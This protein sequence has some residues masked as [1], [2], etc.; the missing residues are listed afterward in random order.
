MR[1][2]LVAV[3][4]AQTAL[5]SIFVLC[6]WLLQTTN[7]VMTVALGI[8]FAAFSITA[9]LTHP[10]RSQDIYHSLTVCRTA[11]D[12]H[13]SPYL[14]TPADAPHDQW[15]RPVAAWR[16]RPFLYGPIW[17]LVVSTAAYASSNLGEALIIV[18][19]LC[20]IALAACGYF[21][22]RIIKDL[23]YAPPRAQ[24]LLSIFLFNPFLIQTSI[25]DAHNDV[26]V[27]LSILLSACYLLRKHFVLS[28]LFLVVGGYI[29]YVP[30]FL[31]PIPIYCLW[32][33]NGS[34]ARWKIVG[35]VAAF[36][37]LGA[38][39]FAPFVRMAQLSAVWRALALIDTQNAPDEYLPGTAFLILLLHVPAEIAKL[40]GV[41]I[42]AF[43]MFYA[44]AKG[45]ILLAYVLPLFA[46]CFFGA[47]FFQPWYFVWLLPFAALF[48]DP[49]EFALLTWFLVTTPEYY[50]P[51]YRALAVITAYTVAIATV[52]LYRR[53]NTPSTAQVVADRES[54][55]DGR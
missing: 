13:S 25:V 34:K 14:T 12:R 43:A 40:I 52:G 31:L 23:G 47:T 7:R 9:V 24:Y 8:V 11:L 19:V 16:D 50:A 26:L 15:S 2:P 6:M 54:G 1:R 28:A 51:Y 39:L 30:W 5:Y 44:L 37:A 32:R 46:I 20:V 35:V 3:M 18:K 29:K 55:G 45:R 49:F 33:V 42:G 22:W 10:T 48:L 4:Y 38:L 21:F 36:I 17:A 53:M 27:L 41:L